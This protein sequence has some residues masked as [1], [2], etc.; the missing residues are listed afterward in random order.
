MS[1]DSFLCFVSWGGRDRTFAWGLQRHLLSVRMVFT[2]IEIL[3]FY[4]A[5]PA[6]SNVIERLLILRKFSIF[7]Q[8]GACAGRKG[9]MRF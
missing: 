1:Q 6:F 5:I 7:W 3:L 8:I 4:K 2:G 9:V